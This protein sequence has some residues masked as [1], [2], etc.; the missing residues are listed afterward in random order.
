MLP[1]LVTVLH[2]WGLVTALKMPKHFRM[3]IMQW[4]W[5]W[6]FASEFNLGGFAAVVISSLE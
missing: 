6:G 5:E 2:H 4:S 3:L 1:L